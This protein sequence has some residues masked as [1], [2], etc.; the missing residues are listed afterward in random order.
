MVN[1]RNPK[2]GTF[3]PGVSGNPAGRPTLDKITTLNI[4]EAIRAYLTRHPPEL[5]RIVKAFIETIKK[6][7]SQAMVELLNRIDGKVTEKHEIEN[8]QSITLVFK[9]VEPQGQL[10]EADVIEVEAK[11]LT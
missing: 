10:P 9:P 11:E 1:K 7:N 8:K 6:G 2:T 5:Q 3:T 4:T